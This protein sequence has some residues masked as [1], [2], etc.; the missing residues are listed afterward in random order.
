MEMKFYRCATCGQM[1]AI[2][3]KKACPIMCCSKP[4]EEVIP[5]VSDGAIKK[6][7]PVYG[8]KDNKVF[9]SVGSVDHPMTNEHYIEWISIK[10]KFGNQRKQLKPFDKPFAIFPLL[11]GDEVLEVYAYFNL[12]YLFKG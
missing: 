1:V 12:H 8:V 11:E 6:H 4:M 3:D 7:V 10:T 2:V 9:V 5:D